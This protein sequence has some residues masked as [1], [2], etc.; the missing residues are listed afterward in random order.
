MPSST[1]LSICPWLLSWIL[2]H[3]D[4]FRSPPEEACH[5][6]KDF[7]CFFKA[8]QVAAGAKFHSR[9]S[10]RSATAQTLP[11]PSASAPSQAASFSAIT[12]ELRAQKNWPTPAV[13]FCISEI[14]ATWCSGFYTAQ[15][16]L[17]IGAW[18]VD[19]TGAQQADDPPAAPRLPDFQQHGWTCCCSSQPEQ[20]NV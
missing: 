11:H 17:P 10:P 12:L 16:W 18:C 1:V 5:T 7:C 8:Q 13:G 19:R 2:A 3:G 6:G 4:A 14:C 9:S 20:G 15:I